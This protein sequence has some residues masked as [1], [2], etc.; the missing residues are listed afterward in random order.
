MKAVTT[1]DFS[2][3][4]KILSAETPS[5]VLDTGILDRALWSTTFQGEIHD[6]CPLLAKL[7]AQG[8]NVNYVSSNLSE[9]TP[10]WNSVANGSLDSVRLLVKR[11]VNVNYKGS[12][13]PRSRGEAFDFAPRAVLRQNTAM[14]RLLISSGVD[15]SVLY[16]PPGSNWPGIDSPR[17]SCRSSIS[18]IHEAA[19]VG[20]VSAI[21]ALLDH[22]AEIDAVSPRVDSLPP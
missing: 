5:H 18:L 10:L 2:K 22:G 1:G 11:G 6:S 12:N 13:R 19:S 17:G 14:L 7:I 9:R 21:K 15:V 8:A 3:A 16:L 20:A 4:L